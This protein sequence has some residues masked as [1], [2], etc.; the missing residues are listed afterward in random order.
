MILKKIEIHQ[1]LHIFSLNTKN[2]YQFILYFV[3]HNFTFF[4]TD[5]IISIILFIF[6][7]GSIYYIRKSYLLIYDKLV[8]D[9][10]D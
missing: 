2:K 8:L 9:I 7:F 6:Y 1:I 5:F 10:Y 3:F 4:Y